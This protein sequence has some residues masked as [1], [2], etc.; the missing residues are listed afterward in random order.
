MKATLIEPE[1]TSKTGAYRVSREVPRCRSTNYCTGSLALHSV[2][3]GRR[4]ITTG[5]WAYSRPPPA[6]EERLRR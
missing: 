5:A 3:P 6:P 1:T 2:V 4:S